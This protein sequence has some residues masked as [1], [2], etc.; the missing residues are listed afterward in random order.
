M[1][2][3]RPITADRDVD[4]M[5]RVERARDERERGERGGEG[6]GEAKDHG[7]E[8]P[9]PAPSPPA[10]ADAAPAGPVEGDDGH[11]HIDIKA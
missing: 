11:L 10:A 5:V 9:K 3:I 7:A 4:P 6:E 2:F 1:D 8:R